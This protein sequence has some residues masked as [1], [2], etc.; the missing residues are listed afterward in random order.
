MGVVAHQLKAQG[1]PH[2]KGLAFSRNTRFQTRWPCCFFILK[3]PVHSSGTQLARL[4]NLPRAA[5]GWAFGLSW[6][7]S[8]SSVVQ[9]L[10]GV[11]H[12]I[13]KASQKQGWR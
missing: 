12:G 11:D 6:K 3:A 1:L 9:V 10:V 5:R 4:R 13:L 7:P 8:R 2:Y